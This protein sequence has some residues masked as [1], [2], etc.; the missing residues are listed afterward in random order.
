MGLLRVLDA[1][2]VLARG[3][4]QILG[5]EQLADRPARA[6]DCLGRESHRV[7]P[8]VGDVPAFIEPLGG[9]HGAPGVEAEAV[10]PLLLQGRC[11]EGCLWRLAERLLFG[12]EDAEGGALE[13]GHEGSGRRFVE[14]NRSVA[15]QL[16]GVRVEVATAGQPLAAERHHARRE[17]ASL[18]IGELSGQVPERGGPEPHPRHLP[19]HQHADGD[20]LH[21]AG[22][23][24]RR[25]LPP[26]DRRDLVAVEPIDDASRF[27]RVD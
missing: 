8:H 17:A 10:V 18:G 3:G 4:R 7:G 11:R 22:G 5:T 20:T 21:P 13:L 14:E 1:A 6:V 12:G 16:S 2:L 9:A 23:K 27:L 15:G 25:D 24:T 26:E 19:L